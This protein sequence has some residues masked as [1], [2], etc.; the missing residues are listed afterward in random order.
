[1]ASM[2]ERNDQAIVDR[3]EWM[4]PGHREAALVSLAELDAFE[5]KLQILP[6]RPGCMDEQ[7]A[8]LLDLDTQLFRGLLVSAV[9][10]LTEPKDSFEF[11]MLATRTKSGAR[12]AGKTKKG[13][14]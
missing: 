13:G 12:L 5:R 1:M 3:V 11:E 9:S 14:R 4:K 10:N 2:A 6:G 7:A 8:A